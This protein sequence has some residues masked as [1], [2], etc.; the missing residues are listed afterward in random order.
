MS[1]FVLSGNLYMSIAQEL[2][3]GLFPAGRIIPASCI[4]RMQFIFASKIN[5][6]G[7][8]YRTAFSGGFL[9]HKN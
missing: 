1:A 7:K 2:F 5:G 4:I 3:N 8:R 9:P 6:N